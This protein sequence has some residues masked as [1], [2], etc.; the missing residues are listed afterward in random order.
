MSFGDALYLHVSSLSICFFRVEELVRVKCTVARGLRRGNKPSLAPNA[1]CITV[2]RCG[3]SEVEDS[4]INW[5]LKFLGLG[6]LGRIPK[7]DAICWEDARFFI[8]F[9]TWTGMWWSKLISRHHC[10]AFRLM[11]KTYDRVVIIDS[12]RNSY[13]ITQT[14]KRKTK[15]CPSG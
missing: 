7:T 12:E 6:E 13:T 3:H 1:V 9:A 5:Y 11:S 8:I 15:K 4:K 14:S 10:L 2:A